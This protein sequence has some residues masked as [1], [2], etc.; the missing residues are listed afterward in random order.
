MRERERKYIEGGICLG[1]VG[2][3]IALIVDWRSHVGVR[4]F[5]P[6]ADTLAFSFI[7]NAIPLALFLSVTRLQI[8]LPRVVRH[9]CI[10]LLMC[11]FMFGLTV[12]LWNSGPIGSIVRGRGDVRMVAT[13]PFGNGRIDAYQIDTYA[14]GPYF[15]LRLQY[16]ILPGVLLSKAL[17]VIDSPIDRLSVLSPDQLCVTL[18]SPGETIL[19]PIGPFASQKVTEVGFYDEAYTSGLQWCRPGL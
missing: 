2:V 15:S 10:L 3:Y 11:G 8:S 18:T 19:V 1:L 12:L 4:L 16:A 5:S 7:L 13:V 9:L 14:F 6:D 17:A